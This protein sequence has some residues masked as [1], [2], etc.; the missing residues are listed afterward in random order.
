MMNYDTKNVDELLTSNYGLKKIM[1]L[2]YNRM[3]M[4]Y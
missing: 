1:K 2:W 3:L 4:N